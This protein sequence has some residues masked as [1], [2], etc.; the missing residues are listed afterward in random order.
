[1]LR[2]IHHV[3][4]RTSD[5]AA[6][7]QRWSIQ[8][9]LTVREQSAERTRLACA[10]EPYSLELVP[11]DTPGADHTGFEL[12]PD[13]TLQDAASRLEAAGVPYERSDGALCLRDPDGYGVELVPYWA[14]PDRRP[15]IARSTTALPGFH[16]RRLGHMNSLTGQLAEQIDFYCRVLGLGLTDRLG[17]EG[18]WLHLGADHHAV[19][20]V[21]KGHYHFHHLAFELTDWGELRVALDHLAQHGRWLAWGPCRHGIGQNLAAYVRIPE[22]EC[23][24][25]LYADMEQLRPDH[26]PRTWPDN[27]HSSNT[28]GILPPRSYFRFDPAAVEWERQGLEALG[29]AL[30]P[31]EDPALTGGD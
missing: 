26:Q 18:A 16:P 23:M 30:P 3:C 5:L 24:V 15:G 31:L 22:E 28:W 14:D 11:S 10:Y 8:F 7:T 1:M 19:A 20:L 12:Q 27:A 9:G 29:H 6:A 2:R 21:G 4:L 17:D 13:V 25:E